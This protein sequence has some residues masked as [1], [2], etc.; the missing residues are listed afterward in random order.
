[1]LVFPDPADDV[2]V[3]IR[4]CV[5]ILDIRWS[6]PAGVP[7]EVQGGELRAF[8]EPTDSTPYSVL[9]ARDM[10]FDAGSQQYLA[11]H[12]DGATYRVEV[13]YEFGT[14]P[15]SDTIRNLCKEV[16]TV[17]CDEIVAIECIV[18]Y[19]GVD[20]GAISGNV[21][22]LGESAPTGRQT[23]LEAFDGPFNNQR[24]EAVDS[25]QRQF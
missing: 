19:G 16:V 14:D 21:E 24:W 20:L 4:E 12:G 22:M 3:D 13:N 8:H 25:T 9:Q 18:P 10:S 2:T 5:G 1:M 7:V 11:V 6:A 15:Y 23:F 17:A